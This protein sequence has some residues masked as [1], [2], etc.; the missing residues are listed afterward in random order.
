[1]CTEPWVDPQRHMKLSI[2]LRDCHLST[3]ELRKEHQKFK[4]ILCY[5]VWTHKTN[6]T[7]VT[8]TLLTQGRV[9]PLQSVGCSLQHRFKWVKKDY[10]A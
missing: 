7:A 5:V 1:M 6:N 4:V 3:R 10:G 9:Q 8:F 2:V